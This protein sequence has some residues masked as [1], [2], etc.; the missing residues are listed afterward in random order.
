MNYTQAEI[1]DAIC[2]VVGDDG[3]YAKKTLFMIKS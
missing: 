3:T 2:F 1:F